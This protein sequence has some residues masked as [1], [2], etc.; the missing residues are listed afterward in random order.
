MQNWTPARNGLQ[1]LRK[2]T[3]TTKS[4]LEAHQSDSF[5]GHLNA[6]DSRHSQSNTRM[7]EVRTSQLG[8]LQHFLISTRVNT[9]GGKTLRQI[10]NEDISG[11]SETFKIEFTL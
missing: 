1:S 10:I 2:T 4:V 6:S 3:E 5:T 9:V 8:T 7:Q 11:S